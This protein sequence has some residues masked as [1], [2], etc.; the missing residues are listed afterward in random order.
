MTFGRT[1]LCGPPPRLPAS[2]T[3]TVPSTAPPRSAREILH[4]L[5]APQG[6]DAG[7]APVGGQPASG[8][9]HVL[10]LEGRLHLLDREPV[11]LQPERIHD[12]LDLPPAAPHQGDGPAVL[13]PLAP[14]PC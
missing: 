7:L 8:D 10:L 2:G 11:R 3:I 5:D 1:K 12:H 14:A 13:S 4:A 6:A 9:L